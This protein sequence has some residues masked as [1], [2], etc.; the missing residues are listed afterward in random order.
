MNTIDQDSRKGIGSISKTQT[1]QWTWS[2]SLIP[3]ANSMVSNIRWLKGWL[4]AR[5]CPVCQEFIFLLGK[6]YPKK[7]VSLTGMRAKH[8]VKD[9]WVNSLIV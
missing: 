6:I 7:P 9:C 2:S 8:Y 4:F 3:C 1:V 5:W